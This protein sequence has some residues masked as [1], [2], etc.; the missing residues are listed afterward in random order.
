M[1]RNIDERLTTAGAPNNEHL[2]LI[3]PAKLG[4]K[5]TRITATWLLLCIV[6]LVPLYSIFNIQKPISTTTG[7]E[8][9]HHFFGLVYYIINKQKYAHLTS[10]FFHVLK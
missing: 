6:I 7:N 4:M 5:L 9:P 3:S 8:I 10:L 1:L 2:S